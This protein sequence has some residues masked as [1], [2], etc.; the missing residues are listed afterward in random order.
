MTIRYRWGPVRLGRSWDT[1]ALTRCRVIRVSGLLSWERSKQLP[2]PRSL[3]RPQGRHQGE[4]AR[5][6]PPATAPPSPP[7]PRVTLPCLREVDL[8]QFQVGAGEVG[9]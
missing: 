4:S 2:V 8:Y 9:A 5:Q 6:S 3:L 7:P 1:P